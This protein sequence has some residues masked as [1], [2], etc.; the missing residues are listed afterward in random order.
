MQ[1]NKMKTIIMFA[2]ILSVSAN[3]FTPSTPVVQDGCKKN[4]IRVACAYGCEPQCGFSP[5]VCGF[6]CIPNSCVCKDGYVRNTNNECV[7]RFD[8][9]AETSRCPEDEEFVECGSMC[10]PTCDDPYPTSCPHDRCVRNE[11]NTWVISDQK[12]QKN[13]RLDREKMFDGVRRRKLINTFERLP[14]LAHGVHIKQ[15][16]FCDLPCRILLRN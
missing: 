3:W 10:P 9:T 11:W 6:E 1:N 4:E 15:H 14:R 13:K 16:N 12:S 8:C 2:V 7:H 5:S